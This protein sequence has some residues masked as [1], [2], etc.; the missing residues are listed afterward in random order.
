[1]A[2]PWALQLTSLL[3]LLLWR[4]PG[5]GAQVRPRFQLQQPQDKVSVTA[6]ETL[7]LTCTPSGCGPTGPL[8]WLKGWGMGNETVYDKKGVFP[9]VTRAEPGSCTNFS[10]YLRDVGPEDAGTYYCVKFRKRIGVYKV[11]EH[12]KG[13]EVSVRAKPTSPVVSGPQHRAG[14]GQSVSVTCVSGGF[15]PENI[16]VRWLKDAASISAQ[17]PRVTPGR[18]KSSYNMSSSVTVTLQEEDVRSQ[19]VCEVQHPTLRAPLR[20]TF[21]LSKVLRVPPRV[22]VV[23]EPPGPVEPNGTVT[24]SCQLEGFYPGEVS[25]TWLENGMEMKVENVSR[26][27]ETR[28][29]LFELRSQVELQATVERNGSVFTCRVVHDGQ[30][31]LS[32]L[33]ALRVTAPA[34]EGTG[35]QSQGGSL[36]SSPALWLGLLLEKGLLGGLLLFLFKRM[37][38]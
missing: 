2:S 9:R 22:R 5:V 23:A 37:M 8:K 4:S 13:T 17:Q 18:T 15:Y 25:V 27:A 3:L 38:A 20:A 24:L 35:G 16:T 30:E 6:G 11:L 21:Q 28:Q 26:A 32:E 14:P 34:Q 31:P 1:M 19:L 12:G 7:T 33:A 10:I 36:L 29:G